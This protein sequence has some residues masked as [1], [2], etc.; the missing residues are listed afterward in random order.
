MV[1]WLSSC[2]VLSIVIK[3]NKGPIG[4]YKKEKNPHCS[5]WPKSLLIKIQNLAVGW[6]SGPIHTVKRIPAGMPGW[7]WILIYNRGTLEH[8]NEWMLPPNGFQQDLIGCN[9]K[10]E[11]S[12]RVK[13][14]PGS[15]ER[16]SQDS[17]RNLAEQ[18]RSSYPLADLWQGW[19]WRDRCHPWGHSVPSV[20]NWSQ[21][22]LPPPTGSCS[23]C[24]RAVLDLALRTGAGSSRGGVTALWC[25][26]PVDDLEKCLGTGHSR[27]K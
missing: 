19:V 6:Y 20:F 17:A 13:I 27:V 26:G 21:S 18:E 2:A 23:L 3:Q 24:A 1:I 5:L 7:F 25:S 16:L 11:L 10:G 22:I 8:T 12:G 15:K 4:N 14:K 9:N